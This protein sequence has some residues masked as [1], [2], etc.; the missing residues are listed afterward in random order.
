[1]TIHTY[2]VCSTYLDR[3]FLSTH[4]SRHFSSTGIWVRES[5]RVC[6]ETHYLPP[7]NFNSCFPSRWTKCANILSE[8]VF[9][10]ICLALDTW[11][12]LCD[13]S[14][15]NSCTGIWVREFRVNYMYCDTSFFCVILTLVF[16]VAGQSAQIFYPKYNVVF[17]FICLSAA[18]DTW[19][20]LCDEE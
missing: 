20:P 4:L 1:M 8:V 14:K 2:R 6:I 10:F 15:K 19:F 11:F 5:M 13:L 12:P 16:R 18:L 17:S 3:S 9:S 7:C